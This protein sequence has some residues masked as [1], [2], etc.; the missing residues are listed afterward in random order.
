MEPAAKSSDLAA[1]QGE[2]IDYS[3][4]WKDRP[5]KG[6][7]LGIGLIVFGA[8]DTDGNLFRQA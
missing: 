6:L 2:G 4:E 1:S 7:P 3:G 5:V 8:W